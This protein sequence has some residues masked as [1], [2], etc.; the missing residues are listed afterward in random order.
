MFV[1]YE[2]PDMH[3]LHLVKVLDK[4][5]VP[6]LVPEGLLKRYEPAAQSRSRALHE[7][8]LILIKTLDDNGYDFVNKHRKN[9]RALGES[10]LELYYLC[11]A[12][13]A[14]LI[15]NDDETLVREHAEI[16][17]V[18]VCTLN[19][20][21]LATVNNKERFDFINEMKMEIKRR[22]ET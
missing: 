1:F 3:L 14:T 21:N 13:N 18:S 15:V 12:E 11:I 16:F 17:G 5:D 8:G 4:L 10:L 2:I 20:F 22:T 19:E 9:F 7:Q 6:I